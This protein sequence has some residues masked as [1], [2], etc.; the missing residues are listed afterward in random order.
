M[1]DRFGR[2]WRV[3]KGLAAFYSFLLKYRLSSRLFTA[4]VIEPPKIKEVDFG[5]FSI[6]AHI[7]GVYMNGWLINGPSKN[8]EMPTVRFLAKDLRDGDVFYEVGAAWGMY[9]LICNKMARLKQCVAFEPQSLNFAE[10]VRNVYLNNFQNTIVL[11]LAVGDESKFD[12]FYVQAFQTGYGGGAMADYDRSMFSESSEAMEALRRGE[13]MANKDPSSL[14]PDDDLPAFEWRERV[15]VMPLDRIISEAKL[16]WPTHMV[17]DIDGGEVLCLKGME[18]TLA[19]P[20]LRAL[21][22]EVDEQTRG[23]VEK[24]LFAAGFSIEIEKTQSRGNVVYTRAR[25]GT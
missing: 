22:I 1:Q 16:E 20:A 25:Q 17:I 11:P 10:T 19:N 6:R 13:G 2:F 14:S 21:S 9:A 3:K 8:N 18:K 5:G 12:D 4:F 15:L 24:I 23:E 7:P